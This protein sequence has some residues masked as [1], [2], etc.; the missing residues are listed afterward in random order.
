[1]RALPLL[2]IICICAALC[3]NAVAQDRG[4]ERVPSSPAPP[5]ATTGSAPREL[6]NKAPVGHRQPTAADAPSQD[7]TQPMVSPYDQKIDR[8][9]KICRDC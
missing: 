6:A 2:A 8:D 1:M 4:R 9:L 5:A 7:T 3:I